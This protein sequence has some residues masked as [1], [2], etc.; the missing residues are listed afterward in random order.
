MGQRDGET[1]PKGSQNLPKVILEVER[2]RG[3]QGTHRHSDYRH[4]LSSGPRKSHPFCHRWP[5][6]PPLLH[7]QT[8]EHQRGPTVAPQARALTHTELQG[9]WDRGRLAP[10]RPPSHAPPRSHTGGSPSTRTTAPRMS[11]PGPQLCCMLLQATLPPVVLRF[12]ERPPG[13]P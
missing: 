1:E 11:C 13:S 5:H 4:R 7:S 2:Q 8:Q 9:C 12:S 10:E 3:T 6:P